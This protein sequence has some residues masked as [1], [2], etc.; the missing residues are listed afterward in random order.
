MGDVEASRDDVEVVLRV[1]GAR[2]VLPAAEKNGRAQ[3]RS[4]V[5]FELVDADLLDG[6]DEAPVAPP[7]P[8]VEPRSCVGG[9]STQVHGEPWVILTVCSATAVCA[10][11][12]S[13]SFFP[14]RAAATPAAASWTAGSAHPAVM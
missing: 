3:V 5:D 2:L 1:D 4:V 6:R 12:R 13:Y 9:A 8:P 14:A 11:T 7:A 10:E